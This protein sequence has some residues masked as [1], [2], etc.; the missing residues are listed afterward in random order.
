VASSVLEEAR[1]YAVGLSRLGLKRGDTIAV[2]GSN[3]PRLYWSIMAGQMLGAVPVPVLHNARSGWTDAP[4]DLASEPWIVAVS[5]AAAAELR[6]A[7]YTGRITV[8]RHLPAPSMP[9][10]A[11]RAR[12]RRA[13]GLPPEM[14]ARHAAQL[15]VD[16]WDQLLERRSIA[17][18]PIEK[19]ARDLRTLLYCHRNLLQMAP[20]MDTF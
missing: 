15:V 13:W 5:Q 6:A 12:W 3:R 18:P 16:E 9:D 8:I 11:L 17:A 7:G 4:A 10:P 14:C 2:I 1:A 20:Y 19:Q